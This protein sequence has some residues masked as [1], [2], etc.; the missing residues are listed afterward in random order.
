MLNG[1]YHLD[2]IRYRANLS[3][4]DV[5]TVLSA[6]ADHLIIFTHPRA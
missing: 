4:K 1:N 3:R 2:E 5:K 6:F